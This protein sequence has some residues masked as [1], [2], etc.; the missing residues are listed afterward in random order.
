MAERGRKRK[1]EKNGGRREKEEEKK[2]AERGRKKERNKM[3]ER[4]RQMNYWRHL[5]SSP[6]YANQI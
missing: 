2:M 3:A 6:V 1:R 4:G 5:Y